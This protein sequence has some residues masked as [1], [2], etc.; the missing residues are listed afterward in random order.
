MHPRRNQFRR[1]IALAVAIAAITAPAGIAA[2]PDDRPHYR[3][4]GDELAAVLNVTPDDRAFSRAGP[5]VAPSSVSP[6]DRPF[7]R[8]GEVEPTAISLDV[9]AVSGFDW[10]DAAIGV[11]FGLALALG[12]AALLKANQRRRPLGSA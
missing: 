12:A 8:G 6:D 11:T 4:S 1:S 10:A 7:A 9:A 5:T 3:G 2:G